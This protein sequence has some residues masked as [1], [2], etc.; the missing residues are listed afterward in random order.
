MLEVAPDTISVTENIFTDVGLTSIDAALLRRKL[1]E[2]GIEVDGTATSLHGGT[3]RSVA[4]LLQ[5]NGSEA[6]QKA[7]KL[8]LSDVSGQEPED[9]SLPRFVI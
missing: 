8:N 6:E 9:R 7:E 4:N 2:Q 1:T 5:S 3:V